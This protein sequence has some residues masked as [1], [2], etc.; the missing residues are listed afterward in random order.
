[1]LILNWF[2]TKGKQNDSP[3]FRKLLVPFKL[4]GVVLADKG[5]LARK[6]YQFVVDKK[7]TAFIPFKNNSTAKK[8]SYPAWTFAFRLWKVLPTMFKGIYHQRSRVEC[9]FLALKKR[10]GDQL[11]SRKVHIHRREMA[12]RFISYNVR[13]VIYLEYSV[14]HNLSLWVRA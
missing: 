14:T 2:I 3:F 10:Y 9:V 7:G 11:Y 5:Y 4:L 12:I 6:N 8:K 13:L 1:M